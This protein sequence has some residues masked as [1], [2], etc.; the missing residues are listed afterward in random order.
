VNLPYAT[1]GTILALGL[2]LLWSSPLALTDTLWILL[3]AYF[4]KHLSFAVRPVTTAVRQTDVALEEAARV[5]G[6][7][8]LTTFRTIWMPLLWPAIAAG[9]FLV[10]MPAFG[11]LTMSVLLVGP[12]TDT[13]GTVLFA[14]QEYADP[15]S[16]S[17][18]AMLILFFILSAYA[19]AAALAP[20]TESE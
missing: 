4:A 19:A 13:V 3:I 7:G 20:R 8:F 12:G 18:V 6:A 5:S 16:A 2:I 9:W 15:P 11:E 10:F 17:V 14:L 1:P